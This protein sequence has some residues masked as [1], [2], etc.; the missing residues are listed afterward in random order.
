MKAFEDEL[1][2]KLATANQ[3]WIAEIIMRCV[4]KIKEHEA[5]IEA[6]EAQIEKWGEKSDEIL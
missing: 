6:M 2:E 1:K 5:K 4:G 3:K